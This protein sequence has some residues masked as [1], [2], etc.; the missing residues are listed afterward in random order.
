M[1]FKTVTMI[2]SSALLGVFSL[3]SALTFASQSEDK[4]VNVVSKTARCPTMDTCRV[5]I[6]RRR[7]EHINFEYLYKGTV[8]VCELSSTVPAGVS[9]RDPVRIPDGVQLTYSGSSYLPKVIR[10]DA[11]GMHNEQDYFMLTFKNHSHLNS[12]VVTSD[13]RRVE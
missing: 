10:V 1:R 13:C 8:F 2:L 4:A 7:E 12:D 6:K 3:G 5:K 9:F 11:R